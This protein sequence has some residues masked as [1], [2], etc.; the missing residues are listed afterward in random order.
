MYR[1]LLVALDGSAFGEHAL[2]LALTIARRSGAAVKLVLVHVP[3]TLM[4][5]DSMTPFSY[6]AEAKVKE[7]E[8]AYLDDVVKRLASA[9]SA[10]VT[11]ELLEG[12][13]VA[14][15]LQGHA[16]SAG[17]DLIVMTTHGHGPLS[18]FWLGSVA[19]EMVRRATT[20][21]L[22]VRPYEKALDLAAEPA[23]R[24]ILIPLDGSALAEQVLEH[25]GELGKVMQSGY[26]FL[27]V[28]GPVVDAGINASH[29][30]AAG[31]EP[32]VEQLRAE[33]QEYLNRVAERL[34]AQGWSVQAEVV[35]GHHPASAI[36]DTA[37]GLPLDLIALETHGRRGVARLLLGSVADKVIRGA[38]M[39]VLVHRSST[40]KESA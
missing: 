8:R 2:P 19:D 7:H 23:L 1:T 26:T 17:A 24:H 3:I 31:L 37:R 21:V 20:P 35:L 15:M 18:R 4:Y 22:L 14:E 28:Y 29:A 40:Q 11:A 5:A 25:A 10:P 12:P 39:P 30:K 36:L 38:S 16:A 13:V 27:R 34:K 6:E 33:A 9:S 32:P